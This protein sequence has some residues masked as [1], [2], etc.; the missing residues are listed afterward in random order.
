MTI[1][2]QEEL[3]G[4]KEPARSVSFSQ[5]RILRWIMDL[6]APDGFELDPT[7][8]RGAM[9]RGGDI[10]QPRWKF[11]LAPSIPGVEKAD[12]RSLPLESGIVASTMFDPPF[13]HHAGEGSR[14]GALYA[15]YF[16][17]RELHAMYADA[18]RELWRVAAPAGI[19]AFK[20]QALI[21]AGKFVATDCAVLGMAVKVGWV[22]V[23]RFTLV[24]KNR[25]KGHNHDRQVH[26]RRYDSTFWVFQRPRGRVRSFMAGA[27]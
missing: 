21:E 6:W 22:D 19:L 4:T 13:L 16:N 14:M 24:S 3:P 5:K 12:V 1:A 9:Y 23:D 27:P 20:C 15:S 11:D 8:A 18:L 26:S 7:Y 2:I 17:Q 25:I 10:P